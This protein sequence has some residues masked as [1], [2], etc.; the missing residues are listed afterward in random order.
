MES[1]RKFSKINKNDV[2]IAGG[3]ET[4]LGE[5][6]Q[7]NIPILKGFVILSNFFEEFVKENDLNV[8][9]DA[10]L[11]KVGTESIHTVEEDLNK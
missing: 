11:A 7:A 5:M 3:K 9:I 1:V 8:E 2:A 6:T 4:S 10:I